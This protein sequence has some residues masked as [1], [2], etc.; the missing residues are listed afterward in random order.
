MISFA[1]SRSS[2]MRSGISKVS[3][4]LLIYKIIF[5]FSPSGDSTVSSASGS[6]LKIISLLYTSLNSWDSSTTKYKSSSICFASSKIFPTTSG[7]LTLLCISQMSSGSS[8]STNIFHSIISSG[9]QNVV[10]RPDSAHNSISI[11]S[12][13]GLSK[14]DTGMFLSAEFINSRQI[15]AG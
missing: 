11:S 3:L 12:L 1:V 13:S 6:C 9:H 15:S 14:S 8:P 4:P 7:T 10:S 5:N 2:P